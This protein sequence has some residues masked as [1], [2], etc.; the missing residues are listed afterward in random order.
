HLDIP[1]KKGEIGVISPRTPK[2]RHI[3]PSADP[4]K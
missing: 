4:V 2:A 1:K 3:N